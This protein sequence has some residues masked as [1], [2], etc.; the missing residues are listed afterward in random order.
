[1]AKEIQQLID[2]AKMCLYPAYGGLLGY[3]IGLIT[4]IETIS[5]LRLIYGLAI[6]GGV[7]AIVCLVE[8]MRI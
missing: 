2:N 7:I 3:F 5:S 8:R 4:N 1:M 6:V